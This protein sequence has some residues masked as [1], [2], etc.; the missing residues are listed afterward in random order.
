MKRRYKLLVI[1]F[2]SFI[3]SVLIYFF[4]KKDNYIFVSIGDKR[5]FNNL[6]TYT[7]IDYLKDQYKDKF[8]LKEYY[9][10]QDVADGLISLIENDYGRINYFLKNSKAITINITG[11]ELNNYKTINNEIEQSYLNAIYNLIN[12]IRKL[13]SNLYIINSITSV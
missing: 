8:L 7:Y 4:V 6:S 12:K 10:N 11:Y 2:I 3:F 5:S 13:N 1:I 9:L